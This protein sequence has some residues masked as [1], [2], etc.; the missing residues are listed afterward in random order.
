V[1]INQIRVCFRVNY[2]LMV[3]S[4]DDLSHWNRGNEIKK[5]REKIS[6]ILMNLS[7]E[8]GH[9][10]KMNI[11]SVQCESGVDHKTIEV[12][13]EEKQIEKNVPSEIMDFID[14]VK[15]KQGDFTLIRKYK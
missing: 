9:R 1:A 5:K 6:N 3:E 7:S 10:Q 15:R 8:Q 4:Y 14:D 13:S 12:K 2:Y 11:P